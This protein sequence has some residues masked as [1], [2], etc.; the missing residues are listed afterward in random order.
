MVGPFRVSGLCLIAVVLGTVEFQLQWVS[1]AHRII[2]ARVTLNSD[3]DGMGRLRSP[4]PVSL[5]ICEMQYWVDDLER[6]KHPTAP[7]SL[8]KALR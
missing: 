6:A 2:N 5:K 7:G 4:R 3:M 1:V 8:G